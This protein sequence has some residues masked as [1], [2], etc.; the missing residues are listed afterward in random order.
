MHGL[1]GDWR[2]TWE[3]AGID[4]AYIH[5]SSKSAGEAGLLVE[6]QAAKG[7]L[8]GSW[9]KSE[10]LQGDHGD[11]VREHL[12]AGTLRQDVDHLL[13]RWCT[14]RLVGELHVLRGEIRPE[15]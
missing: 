8:A 12:F 15:V 2:Y 6:A 4:P 7:E 10:T 3:T 11:V 14:T 13:C 1:G 5:S 9:F